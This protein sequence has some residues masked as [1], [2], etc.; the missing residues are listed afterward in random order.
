MKKSIVTIKPCKKVITFDTYKKPKG[1]LLEVVSG[2]DKFTKHLRGQVYLSVL[3]PKILMDYHLHAQADYFVTCLKGKVVEV[4]YKNRKEKAPKIGITRTL[5]EGANESKLDIHVHTGT[6]VDAPYHV[7]DNG[8]RI[9]E[10]NPDKFMGKCVVLDFTK[11]KNSI[12]EISILLHLN[13]K[14]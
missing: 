12:T 1:W 3:N 13:Y 2:S 5:K 14:N 6:H 8:K 7:L 9:D 11:E 10:L 4:I